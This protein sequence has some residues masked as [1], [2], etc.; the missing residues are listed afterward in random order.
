M[1]SAPK[2]ASV[3][4]QAGPATTRVKSTTSRPSRAVGS[5]FARGV[6]LRQL[7]S[8]SHVQ[9][10]PLSGS[11]DRAVLHRRKACDF[12]SFYRKPTANAKPGFCRAGFQADMA[13]ACDGRYSASRPCGTCCWE[14]RSR[15]GPPKAASIAAVRMSRW[16]TTGFVRGGRSEFAGIH[17]QNIAARH[18]VSPESSGEAA[19]I[20]ARL[21]GSPRCGR[22]RKVHAYS[23]IISPEP[24]NS[25]GKSFNL[26]RP[27]RIGNT[28]SA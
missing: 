15:A 24:P 6:A 10:F 8:G 14:H 26:G 13:T 1:T 9:A 2:S 27:S 23:V 7:R 4:V 21:P 20:G 18:R 22:C 16:K 17:A 5:P 28:V 19:P 25:A 12:R 3:C 11:A